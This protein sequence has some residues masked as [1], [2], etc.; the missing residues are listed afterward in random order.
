MPGAAIRGDCAIGERV[1]VGTNAAVVQGVS[2]GAG[3][4]VGAGAVVPRDVPPHAT[5][6]G[7]LSFPS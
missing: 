1:L 3:A 4:P 5:D 7:P 6:V 2:I